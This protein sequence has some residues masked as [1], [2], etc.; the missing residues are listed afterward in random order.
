MISLKAD[1]TE[2]I[3]RMKHG[4]QLNHASFEEIYYLVFNP[5]LIL[6]VKRQ[7]PAWISRLKN[8]GW[9]PETFSISEQIIAIHREHKLRKFWLSAESK[10]PGNAVK[11]NLSLANALSTGVLL[12]RL[13]AALK[14]LE[15][16]QRGLLVVTDL[17]GLHPYIRIGTIEGKLQGKFTVPT[18]ILYPGTRTGKTRLKFLGFYPEDGNYRSVHV[19]G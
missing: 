12:D 18:L 2:V 10:E 8:E 7:T 16:K 11:A 19:G 9:D 3:E 4:R 15:T 1:F 6:D 13:E 5:A 14:A 17:E